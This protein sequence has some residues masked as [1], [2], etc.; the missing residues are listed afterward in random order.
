MFRIPKLPRSAVRNPRQRTPARRFPVDRKNRFPNNQHAHLPVRVM[1]KQLLRY[2]SPPQTTRSSGDS[3]NTI[4]GTFGSA[5]KAAANSPQL[6]SES[7]T[8]GSWPAGTDEGPHKY[9]IASSTTAAAAATKI[10]R[11]FTVST[12]HR[13]GR[14]STPRFLEETE[15]CSKPPQRQP[16]A[17]HCQA[18][19]P[20]PRIV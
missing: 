12:L 8:R 15:S 19:F 13:A 4:R 14:Q 9:A 10:A 17:E 7:V 3:S 1:G 2:G 20:G 5:L 6:A 18:F 16:I 11:L